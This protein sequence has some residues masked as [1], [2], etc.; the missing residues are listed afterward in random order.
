MKIQYYIRIEGDKPKLRLLSQDFAGVL[1]GNVVDRR[2]TGH[3]LVDSGLSYWA[4]RK[5]DSTFEN[6]SRDLTSFLQ[7][8]IN[9]S[10]LD[11][12]L[13]VTVVVV[14]TCHEESERPGIYLEAELIRLMGM[15][16]ASL[17]YDVVPYLGDD[18]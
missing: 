10:P 5:V 9:L 6:L 14:A 1:D 3:P 8:V 2:G 18:Q 7:A 15:L 13:N 12:G 17:D 11:T 16:G 4:S